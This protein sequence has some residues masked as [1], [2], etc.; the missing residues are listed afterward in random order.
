MVQEILQPKDTKGGRNNLSSLK[1]GNDEN[2]SLKDIPYN[3]YLDK[4]QPSIQQII[5]NY[6]TLRS[7]NISSEGINQ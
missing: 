3:N 6:K 4:I 2:N 1:L 5:E 7:L